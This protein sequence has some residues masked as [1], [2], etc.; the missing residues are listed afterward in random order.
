MRDRSLRADERALCA[1]DPAPGARRILRA[2]S[3]GLPRPLRLGY[4]P[5]PEWWRALTLAG[6]GVVYHAASYSLRVGALTSALAE[7]NRQLIRH[8]VRIRV[9]RGSRLLVDANSRSFDV[10]GSELEMRARNGSSL[11]AIQMTVQ[12]VIGFIRLVHKPNP[13]DAVVRGARGQACTSVAAAARPSLPRS[14]C[15]RIGSRAYVV[16]SFNEP[17]FAGDPLTIWVLTAA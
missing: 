14:G 17:G 16:R 8:V 3:P 6:R 13:A 4:E 9:L 5:S 7:A 12:D 2:S 10:G 1:I 11:G 15:T